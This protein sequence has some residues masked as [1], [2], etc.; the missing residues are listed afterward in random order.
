MQRSLF[1]VLAASL[2]ISCQQDV[3]E[4]GYELHGSA[5]NIPDSTMIRLSANNLDL[6]SAYVVGEKFYFSGKVEEPTNVYLMIKETGDYTSFW[7]EN[8]EMTLD[9]EKGKFKDAKITGSQTEKENEILYSQISPVRKEIDSLGKLLMAK[10]MEKSYSD[11]IFAAY[12]SKREK[13]RMLTKDFV[14]EY[15]N[16]LVSSHILKIYKTTW[17]KKETSELFAAMNKKQQNSENGKSISRFIELN[18]DLEVGDQYADITQEDVNGKMISLSNIK[19]KYTLL[20]FWASWCGPC[21]QTNPELVKDY[22]RFKDQGF[23]I[24]AVSLDDNKEF[25]IKAIKKDGLLY[26]NVSD[27]KGSEN[28]GSLIYGVNGI[29]DNFLIDENGTIIARH[30]RGAKLTEKLEE[31]FAEVKLASSESGK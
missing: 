4:K 29:P 22:A 2:F 16:S 9:A 25:W 11:S 31:L 8:N 3:K 13:E 5:K 20:E 10:G 27:L 26:P 19:G 24:Y 30:L 7:L 21:R 1:V 18:Q 12:N 15:P 23:E 17:G 6:D 28:E 14:R